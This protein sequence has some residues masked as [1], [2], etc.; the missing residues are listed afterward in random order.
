MEQTLGK[1]IVQHRKRLNLTQEQLAESLGVT[2]QAVSKWENDQSCPDINM[3]PKLAQ[4][5]GTT[6]DALLGNE[7]QPVYEAE[8]VQPEE[9]KK[10]WSFHWDGG[11]RSRVGLAMVLVLLGI[12]LIVSSYLQRDLS[13]WALLWP[14]ALVIFGAWGIF[15]RFSFFNF[16]CFLFG[17]YFLLDTWELLPISLGSEIVLPVILVLLGLSVLADATH[18]PK[19]PAISFTSE[20][21]Q[22]Y[23]YV[24][25]NDSFVLDA[26][27]GGVEQ[28][29]TLSHLRRGDINCCFG[30]YTVDLTQV[31]TVSEDC[32]LDADCSF[33]QLTLL[34][35]RRFRIRNSP[36]TAFGNAEVIGSPDDA[37]IGTIQ[38]DADISFA[39]LIIEY[40]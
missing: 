10:G 9:K 37:P 11:R 26:S 4:L 13:F 22:N 5:F 1:R 18:R 17:G 30:S 31:Q 20:G 14:T 2:A 16:G 24:L 28:A 23:D 3:L 38:L 36:S 25:G 21:K 7:T 35:P 32:R 34:I 12:Q 19:K 39:K 40:T 33:G 15:P 6:V 8:V 29:V 27:F